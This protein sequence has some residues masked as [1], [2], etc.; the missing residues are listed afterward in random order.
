MENSRCEKAN[1]DKIATTTVVTILNAVTI[2]VF[3][4]YL[5]KGAIA[6]AVLKLLHINFSG[7][8]VGGVWI[9]SKLD[10]KED[11]IIQ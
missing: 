1:A 9:T 3:I 11:A 6:N 2:I 4:K 5:P 10:F 8:I 7:T